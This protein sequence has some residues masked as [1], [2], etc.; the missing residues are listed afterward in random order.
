MEGSIEDL[1][2]NCHFEG[3]PALMIAA[4]PSNDPQMWV[5]PGVKVWNPNEQEAH[6]NCL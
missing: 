6:W 5:A 2:S 1:R 4:Q 3:S